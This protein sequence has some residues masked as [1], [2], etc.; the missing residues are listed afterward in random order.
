MMP[1]PQ[2]P[3][4]DPDAPPA[5]LTEQQRRLWR[6][7]DRVAPP[8]CRMLRDAVE[9]RFRFPPKTSRR[10]RHAFM[11]LMVDVA[12]EDYPGARFIITSPSTYLAW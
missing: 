10:D 12:A 8:T 5:C 3:T 6:L 2:H 11:H 7:M 4:P 9:V 1:N